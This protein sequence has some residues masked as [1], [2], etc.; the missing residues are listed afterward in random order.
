MC[1]V[2]CERFFFSD[3][4]HFTARFKWLRPFF[5]RIYPFQF[6]K[7]LL[8]LSHVQTSS[9]SILTFIRAKNCFVLISVSSMMDKLRRFVNGDESPDEESGIIQQVN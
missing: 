1:I 7:H 3:S 4:L 2:G 6:I 9:N 8:L 5:L